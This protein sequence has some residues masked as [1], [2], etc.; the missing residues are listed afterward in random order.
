MAEIMYKNLQLVAL[1]VLLIFVSD[2]TYNIDEKYGK[3]QALAE[4]RIAAP[5]EADDGSC[6]DSS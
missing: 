3:K 2:L 1:T 4:P 5:A 6:E